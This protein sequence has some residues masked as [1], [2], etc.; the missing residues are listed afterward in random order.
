[1]AALGYPTSFPTRMQV[2]QADGAIR[3]GHFL[4]AFVIVSHIVGWA[5]K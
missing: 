4:D 1:M 3:T 2:L 5:R